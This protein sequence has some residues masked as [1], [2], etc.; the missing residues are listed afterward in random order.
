[1]AEHDQDQKTELP[2]EKRLNDAHERGQFA[3]SPELGVVF[4]LAAA[5]GALSL[6]AGEGARRVAEFGAGIFGHI[7]LIRIEPGVVPVQ[8]AQAGLVLAGAL[9][10]VLVAGI[11]AALMSGGLQ[12]G[13]QL[14]PKAFGVKPERLNPVEGFQRV[15]SKR[16]LTHGAIDFLKVT[17]IG[18]SLWLAART[19]LGDPLF[20]T[21]VET[22]YLGSFIFE[23]ALA[24]L[25]RLLLAMSVIAAIAYSYERYKTYRELMMT[26]QELK[27][28]RRQSEGD[29]LVK[30]AMRRMAR[31]LMQRQMLAAVP[32]ADVVV[33]NPTH[34]AVALK[35]ERGVDSAPVVLAK[36]ENR[37]AMRIKAI[38]AEHGV[39]MVEDRA[40]AKL[41]H[42]TGVV[43]EPIPVSLY[44]AVAAILVMVYRTHRYYFFRLK[45]RR[46]EMG[47]I[48]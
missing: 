3:K 27:E 12:T 15:F 34:Y 7:H 16:T 8:F 22:P 39:P 9:G 45:A 42:G 40:V 31:R 46:A 25:A 20:S 33:T 5:F 38:A 28:E 44:K 37:L 26:R 21:P 2:S 17:A 11:V 30:S 23:S 19:L 24:L 29:A 10:P 43:G 1:M 47:G 13:F 32:T 4:M 14:T 48:A 41:L 35:Y 6:S 18:V 36:G